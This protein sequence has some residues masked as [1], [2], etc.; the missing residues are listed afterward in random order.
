VINSHVS[1]F[2]GLPVLPFTPGTPLPEDPSGVAWR[3]AVDDFEAEPEEFADLLRAMLD[4]VPVESVRAV[5]IGEWGSAYE[6]EPPLDLLVAAADRWT[7]LRALF[8]ADLVSEECEISWL[9][10]DD[11]TPL[12]TAYPALEVLWIRGAAGLRLDPVRHTGLRELRIESGGLPGAVVRA[13][14][15]SDLPALHRLDLWL[16]RAGYGGDTT[17]DDLA[18]ILSGDRLPALRHLAPCNAENADAV[19]AAVAVAPVVGQL[20]VLDLSMGTLTDPGAEALLAGQPLTHLAAL[21]LHHHFLS[22]ECQQ[23]LVAALPGVRVDLSDPQ[24][25]HEYRGQEYHYTAVG[26]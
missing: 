22:A 23:R 20:E 12:L 9:T 14:G 25:P 1:S 21:D 18:P 16:G 26:E 8:L 24:S 5:V 7:G 3:L 13:V 17:V 4:E 2:A 10:L 19:A 6:R 11:V 15:A